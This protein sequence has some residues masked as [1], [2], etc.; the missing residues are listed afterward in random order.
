M[1]V[2]AKLWVSELQ[3][4]KRLSTPKHALLLDKLFKEVMPSIYSITINC[5]SSENPTSYIFYDIRVRKYSYIALV[6]EAS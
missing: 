5:I 3:S 4:A 2:F 6:S 1:S